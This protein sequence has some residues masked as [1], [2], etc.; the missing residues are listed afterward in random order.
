MGAARDRHVAE[1]HVPDDIRGIVTC[2]LDLAYY[3]KQN[4][5]VA[6]DLARAVYHELRDR[7]DTLP[8]RD[9]DPPLPREDPS[10]GKVMLI[11]FCL[12]FVC[13]AIVRAFG[14]F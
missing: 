3:R 7:V 12:F 9:L 4:P 5:D 11:G 14:A 8:E 2:A 6:D 10:W 1:A 13:I